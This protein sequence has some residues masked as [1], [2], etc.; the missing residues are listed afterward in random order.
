MY[1]P[2]GEFFNA[3]FYQLTNKMNTNQYTTIGNTPMIRLTRYEPNRRV[4]IYAKYEGANQGGSIKD[5]VALWM[6]NDAIKNNELDNGK[7]LIE[8][9]SGNTGIGLAMIASLYKIPVNIVVPKTISKERL[10]LLKVYGAKVMLS[11]DT[12]GLVKEIV[13]K[14]PKKYIW[15]NQYENNQSIQAHYQTT[16]VEII[17]DT[18]NITHFITG[19]GTGGTVTGVSKRLKEEKPTIKTYGIELNDTVR[20][21]GLRSLSKYKPPIIDDSV[22]DE[23][24]VYSDESASSEYIQDLVKGVGLLVGPSSGVAL[25]GAVNLAKTLTEGVIVT[26]FPDSGERYLSTGVFA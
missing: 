26:I 10:G 24:I 16:G 7:E 8:A 6:I 2:K 20:V 5:R 25:W 1:S 18:P 9:S 19:I 11:K 12:I 21:P 4:K 3:K 22:I 23:R 17:R 15:L 14:Q 13:R